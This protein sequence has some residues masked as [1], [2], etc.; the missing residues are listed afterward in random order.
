MIFTVLMTG[1]VDSNEHARLGFISVARHE[2]IE[3]AVKTL[4]D[5]T[6]PDNLGYDIREVLEITELTYE[7]LWEALL[8][9]RSEEKANMEGQDCWSKHQIKCVYPIPL[10][11]KD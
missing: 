9:S 4:L 7:F 11:Q 1:V 3:F 2:D 8:F 5:D 10:P 6:F